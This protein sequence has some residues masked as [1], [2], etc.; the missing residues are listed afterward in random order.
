MIYT[1]WIPDPNI[2]DKIAWVQIGMTC[3]MIFVNLVIII[4]K[5]CK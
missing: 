4:Q 2:Q 1:D 3:L 5:I